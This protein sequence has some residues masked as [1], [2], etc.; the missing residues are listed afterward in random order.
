MSLCIY[1]AYAKLRRDNQDMIKI[2]LTE[3]ESKVD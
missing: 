3:G 2:K 1:E